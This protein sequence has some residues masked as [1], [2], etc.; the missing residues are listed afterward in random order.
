M[1]LPSFSQWKQIFKVLKRGEKIVLLA[2]LAVAIGS[3]VFLIVNFYIANT[4]VVPA[5]GDAYIEGVVGQPRFINPIYGET[6]DIDRSLISLVFSGLMTYDKE[7]HIVKDLADSYKIS[8]DGKVYEFSL[9]DNLFWHDGKP[10]TSD[11]IIFTIKTIQN[12]DYRSPLRASWIDVETEKV[13]DKTLKLILRTPYNSFLES[14][15]LKIL[16]S[17]IWEDISPENFL[18]SSYNLQPIGSGPYEFLKISQAETGFITSIDLKKNA[19]YYSQPPYVSELLFNFFEKKDDLMKAVNAKHV[20]GFALAS[21]ENIQDAKKEIRQNQFAIYSFAL[22]RYFAVFFNINKT[23]ALPATQKTSI[24]SDQNVRKALSYAVNKDELIS[25][26]SQENGI[27]KVDSPILPEFFGY[28]TPQDTYHYDIQKAKELLDKAGFVDTGNNQRAKAINRQPAFQFKS[29]LKQG[30][31]GNEVTQLQL[32]LARLD[33]STK[34]ALQDETNGTYGKKTD[35]AVTEFQKKYLPEATPTGE[36]GTGTRKKLNELCIAQGPNSQPLKF[37][38]YTI[39]QPQLEDVANLLKSYWQSVGAQVDIQTAPLSELKTIIKDRS[40]DALLYGETL[41]AEPD[42][43]PFWH[44]SQKLDPGL[45]LSGY[46]SKDADKLIK[47]ARETMDLTQK[48]VKYE[49]LQNLIINNAPALFLYNPE[50]HY[51]ISP[52]IKG[53]DTVKIIDPAKRFVNVTNWY[54]RTR[55]VWK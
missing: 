35:A 11:D 34:N 49:E 29:Y 14:C 55:R 51:W 16:P 3:F 21:L 19:R 40:Y 25:N 30:S 12:S 18:L 43:Y 7:G 6:N 33:E 38:L 42:L 9:K 39:N 22:P 32:C 37:T 54:S 26:I 8:S 44:S 48:K 1:A 2:L 5:A 52:D 46:E 24:F 47:E 23:S 20:T 31:K 45:N 13:S 17:H 10:L 28:N 50:Y 4:K 41:G 15:T 53:V 36:V 27:L